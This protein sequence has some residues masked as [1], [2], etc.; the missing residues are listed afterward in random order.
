M[1]ISRKK[2]APRGVQLNK[3]YGVAI[4]LVGLAASSSH[5]HL[6]NEAGGQEQHQW[7][8]PSILVLPVLTF[9]LASY[10]GGVKPFSSLAKVTAS[11]ASSSGEQL[12]R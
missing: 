3:G 6:V 12:S 2:I 4:E 8:R 5:A 11:G 10:R 9:R 1:G 7:F